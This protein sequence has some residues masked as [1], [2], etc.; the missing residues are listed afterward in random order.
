MPQDPEEDGHFKNDVEHYPV[1]GDETHEEINVSPEGRDIKEED[2]IKGVVDKAPQ[3]IGL[4]VEKFPRHESQRYDS[5][6]K[7]H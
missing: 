7:C 5:S 1:T 4:D 6:R 3:Y 2:E